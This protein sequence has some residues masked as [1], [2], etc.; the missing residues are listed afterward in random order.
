[1]YL[2]LLVSLTIFGFGIQKK[3]KFW[4]RGKPDPERFQHLGVRLKLTLADVFLHKKILKSKFPGFFHSLIFYSFAVLFVTTAV[5]FIDNDFGIHVFKGVCYVVLSV[6]SEVAGIFILVGVA[7]AGWRR[8]V[9]KPDTLKTNSTDAVSLILLTLIVITGYLVEGLRIAVQGDNWSYLSPLGNLL[10][11]FFSGV[12][13]QNGETVH[14]SIWWLHTFLVFTWIATLPYTRFFHLLT[15]PA[16]LFFRKIKPPGELNRV[17]L[18]ALME[19]EDFDDDFSLGIDTVND[20]T[21]KQRL[22][23]DACLSCG[24]CE[25]VCPTYLSK[26]PLSP[27]EFIANIKDLIQTSDETSP[28]EVVGNAFAEDYIWYCRTCLACVKACPVCVE[29]VD[30]LFEIRR[31]EVNIKGR[32]PTDGARLIKKMESVGNPFGPPDDRTAWM[33]TLDAPILHPGEECDVLY[34]IGCLTSFDP[35][36]QKIAGKLIAVLKRNNID[37][38]LLGAAEHCCGDPVRVLGEEN[39][40]Q[41]IAKEQV[42]ELNSLKFKTL[43]VSCPHCYTVIKNEYPQFGGQYQVTHH[44]EFLN[45]ILKESTSPKPDQRETLVYHDACYLG[46]Y[47]DIYEAPRDLIRKT[48]R[49]MAAEMKNNKERSLCCGSGGGHFWMDL[50][51]GENIGNL[52]IRQAKDTGAGTIITSCPYCLHMLDESIK[53]LSLDAEIKIKDIVEL[54]DDNS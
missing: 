52:R 19:S 8:Y 48:G 54:I 5:V 37:V 34:W 20:F 33:N 40:Y 26:Q 32:I 12:S 14:S 45:E 22:D 27:R 51:K 25:E 29:Q 23:A 49:T 17:D 11:A 4:K 13:R 30:T 6:A 36:K 44:S 39:L 47:Q 46:R 35:T 10:A 18:E 2:M 24:R 16:N 38:R 50:K 42:K 41:T 53:K 7:M 28:T 9:L 21:W 1:M 15:V 31:N 43:L 3:I